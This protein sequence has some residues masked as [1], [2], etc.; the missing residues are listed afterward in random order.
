MAASRWSVASPVVLALCMIMAGACAGTTLVPITP[1]PVTPTPDP[2]PTPQPATPTPGP[3]E[4]GEPATPAAPVEVVLT[5]DTATGAEDFHY[6]TDA[7][8]AAAGSKITLT[9]HNR[10]N[11]DDE[12]GHNWVL[13]QP[14]QEDSVLA[15]GTA[16]GDDNDWLDKDDPG[17]IAATALIEGDAKDKITFDAPAPGTYTF[18]CTFPE[19][20]A[21]GM[22]GTL[23]IQ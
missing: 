7:L 12:V 19:H 5:I 14:G 2:T 4:S 16:A 9:F 15:S 13:V 8:S 3:T 21:G 10:T 22:K 23:T 20:F 17:I 18:L 6:A 11:P 1:P